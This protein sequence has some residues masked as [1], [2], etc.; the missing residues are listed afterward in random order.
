M[1]RRED[2]DTQPPRPADCGRPRARWLIA[3]AGAVGGAFGS[4]PD[5]RAGAWVTPPDEAYARIGIAASATRHWRDFDGERQ[6]LPDG[7][8]YE[9][10]YAAVYVAMGIERNVELNVA[11]LAKRAR[12]E[13]DLEDATTRGLGDLAVGL[14]VGLGGSTVVRSLQVRLDVPTF[15]DDRAV[16]PLGDGQ[17]DVDARALVGASLWS[18][19]IPGYLGVEAGYR[20][21]AEDPGDAWVYMVEAGVSVFED[22]GVRLK[23]DGQHAFELPTDAS[24][25]ELFAYDSRQVRLDATLWFAIAGE[26]TLEVGH[27]GVLEARNV[28]GGDAWTLGVSRRFAVE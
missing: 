22:A 20:H 6:P 13:T 27:V 10:S 18:L 24:R 3:V 8:R 19:G 9:E 12:L 16:P 11:I 25:T 23:L 14:K 15:Y 7:G 5:A 4:V 28:T 21:R 2:T 1:K 26:T 17:L